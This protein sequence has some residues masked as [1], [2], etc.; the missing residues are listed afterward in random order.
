MSCEIYDLSDFNEPDLFERKRVRAIKE[1]ICCECGNVI[2]IKE[3]YYRDRGLWEGIFSTHKTC[4]SCFE[5]R[6]VFFNNGYTYCHLF[7]DLRDCISEDMIS[8]EDIKN[9]SEDSFAVV[10]KIIDEY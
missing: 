6:K 3:Y 1:H 5:I 8:Y 9:L 7:S 2:K 10:S 4:L